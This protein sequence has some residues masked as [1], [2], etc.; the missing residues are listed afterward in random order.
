MGKSGMKVIG[1]VL[2]A[3][4]LAYQGSYIAL[5]LLLG[6]ALL[7]ERE[8][9]LNFQ[10]GQVLVLRVLYDAVLAAWNVIH[11]V[12]SDLFE[13]FDANHDTVRGLHDFNKNFGT[14][15]WY[16]F[17]VLLV[18]GLIAVLSSK[19]AKIPIISGLTKKFFN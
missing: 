19:E 3:Y 11:R 8:A 9:V 5:L 1:M 17:I 16:V 2:L 18:I 15:A 6:F 12:L 13:M 4:L 10:I 7:V 14:V